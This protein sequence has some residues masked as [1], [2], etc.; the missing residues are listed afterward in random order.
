MNKETK[1]NDIHSQEEQTEFNRRKLLKSAAWSAP[2]VLAISLPKHA[3][4]TAIDNARSRLSQSPGRPMP[5]SMAS[6][7]TCIFDR[8]T[9]E[10]PVMRV[11]LGTTEV[12]PVP[13][14]PDADIVGRFDINFFSAT[15]GLADVTFSMP[16]PLPAGVSITIDPVQAGDPRFFELSG[17]PIPTFSYVV[18]VTFASGFCSKAIFSQQYPIQ[19]TFTPIGSPCEPKTITRNLTFTYA[20]PASYL[21]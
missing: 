5:S 15:G 16:G 10:S 20:G 11:G 21:C 8:A 6:S 12:L 7:S 1:G 14:P 19:A 4:A 17:Q 2:V 18:Q 13:N 3:Q 9:M